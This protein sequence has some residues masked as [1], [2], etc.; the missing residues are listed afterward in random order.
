MGFDVNNSCAGSLSHWLGLLNCLEE[1]VRLTN[2]GFL[3][4][5]HIVGSIPDPK[6]GVPSGLHQGS[7]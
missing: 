7:H 1:E 6:G 4:H 5:A 2:M 3:D